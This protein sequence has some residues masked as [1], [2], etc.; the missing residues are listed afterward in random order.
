MSTG[1]SKNAKRNSRRVRVAKRKIKILRSLTKAIALT[2]IFTTTIDLSVF[3]NRTDFNLGSTT[4]VVDNC[5]TVTVFND[6]ILFVGELISSNKHSIVTVGG[7][8]YEP[9]HVGSSEAS[10][11][12][13]D[14]RI[15]TVTISR[16]LHFPPSPVNVLSIGQI[17][18]HCLNE[19]CDKDTCIKSIYNKSWF[20]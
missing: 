12:D 20:S 3:Q 1:C 13:N 19:I 18:L 10:V 14:G 17:S 9:T 5:A 11:R 7:S 15:L 4:V 16:A 6:K 2:T 8:N